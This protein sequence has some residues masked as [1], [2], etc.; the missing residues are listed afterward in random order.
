MS[1]CRRVPEGYG[2]LPATPPLRAPGGVRGRALSLRFL[3][4]RVRPIPPCPRRIRPACADHL[5]DDHDD[6]TAAP[7]G[8]GAVDPLRRPPVRLG[9]RPSRL[10][11][12][13]GCDHSD[14]GRPSSSRDRLRADRVA[15]DQ[16]WR[17]GWLGHRRPP[18]RALRFHRGRARPVRHRLLRP[19]GSSGRRRSPARPVRAPVRSDSSSTRCRPPSR[20][21]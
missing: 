16:P 7:G 10:R 19:A 20:P 1:D 4:D 2:E 3:Y 17:T 14:L 21:S 18:E 8:T 12:P 13:R 11:P 6:R 5:D 15:R 9:D